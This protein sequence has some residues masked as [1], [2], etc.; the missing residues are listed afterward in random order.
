MTLTTYIET[1][2]SSARRCQRLSC[3]PATRLFWDG[4]VAAY[5]DALAATQLHFE[6]KAVAHDASPMARMVQFFDG[7]QA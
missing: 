5:E 2:L 6:G 1:Q 4:Q 7:M 3:R